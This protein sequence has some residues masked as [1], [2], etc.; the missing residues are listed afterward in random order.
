MRVSGATTYDYVMLNAH[1]RAMFRERYHCSKNI[2]ELKARLSRH[3]GELVAK[4]IEGYKSSRGCGRVVNHTV[5]RIDNV[6]FTT[7][8]CGLKHPLT[9]SL[10]KLSEYMDKGLLPYEGSVMD[11]PAQIMELIDIVSRAKINEQ[12]ELRKDK[13]G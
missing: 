11:Q 4:K 5:D 1:I 12:A 3:R 8:L 2:E 7:C 6:R 13:N 10:L 9:D